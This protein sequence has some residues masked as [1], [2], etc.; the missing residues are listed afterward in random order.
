MR[1]FLFALGLYTAFVTTLIFDFAGGL[2]LR[3]GRSVWGRGLGVLVLVAWQ[4]GLRGE[5]L[6]LALV[7]ESSTSYVS[8][9]ETI[10]ALNDGVS[11]AHSDDKSSGAYGNWPR[12]GLQWVEYEWPRAIETDRV[13]VY[14]FDDQRGVRVPASVRLK[15]WDGGQF[16]EVGGVSGL[17]LERDKFNV[18]SFP[19]VSTRRLRLEFE[20]REEFS[21]GLL[22]WRVMDT[23]ASPN[24]AP[25][26]DAGVD[27]VVV[28]GGATHLEGV[29]RDDGKRGEV[30][31]NWVKAGG[32]GEVVFEDASALGTTAKFSV[33]GEYGVRLVANDGEFEAVD[34]VR[35]RVVGM[36]EGEPL[37]VVSTAGYSVSSSFW[38]GRLKP[39]VV[40]WIPHCI[41]KIEDV[42]TREGGIQNFVEAGRK[43][44]GGR[45]ARHVG[46]VFSNAWVYNTLE[47]MCW[48]LMLD[49]GGDEEV[50]E[51]QGMI[52]RTLED[53]IPKILSAQEPDGYLH[54]Q[55]TIEGRRRWSNKHDHED[56]MAG[57][58][59]EA[60]IAHWRLEGGKDRRMYDAA[61]RLADCWVRNLGEAGGRSWYPGHQ[62]MELALVRW[63]EL[64]EEVEGLGK[65][66]A[67]VGLSKWLLE[68]R[69]GGEEYDQS[70]V[71]VVRQ[72]EAVGHAV[73]AVYSYA[74]MVDIAMRT[75]DVDYHSAVMSIWDNLVNRKYYVTGGVGSGETS[76]GFG[77]D[78]SLPN[79][80]YCETCA[81]SGELFF[82]Y[83]MN[84]VYGG[85]RYADLMEETLYNAILGGMDL[86]GRNYTYTNPLDSGSARYGWHGCPCC[87]GNLPR[88]LLQLPTWMYVKGGGQLLVNM[89]VGSRVS[90]GEVSGVGVVV[91][92]ETDYPW[93]GV[94]KLRVEPERGVRFAL[95]LRVPDWETSE[96]YRLDPVVAG[97]A[98][99]RV[100]GEEEELVMHNGYAMVVREW[101]A[102]DVVEMELPMDIQRVRCDERVVA[103]RGRVAL[104]RGPLVYNFES[105]D[106]S[107]DGVL[108]AGSPLRS[109]WRGDL[110][111]GVEVIRGRFVDGEEFMAV[112]NYVRLN[113]GGRS[114]VWVREGR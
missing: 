28:V 93:G 107:V 52:R 109:E 87:V 84:R 26:V 102:G 7:A 74:G 13:E 88:T 64:V 98:K 58:F 80:A 76:E 94:V 36:P 46:P 60:A 30:T 77:E 81:G 54:T 39:L 113:R 44:A 40:N 105:V 78:Y 53:W 20:G 79:N 34:E 99:L 51:A 43:L 73:R 25:R 8:G 1:C 42:D 12:T 14:W 22:E 97:G 24:F 106:Q 4:A 75:G 70:H 35:V 32:A 62:E 5:G 41:R 57:Y 19:K 89:Y 108:S 66:D 100:N 103:N 104:R 96:L 17:G 67:Y 10:R 11:P 21:T 101:K 33:E 68:Q 37:E 110:L 31:V 91:E 71:P 90:V 69:R 65:G 2:F 72:Y 9:H 48:A 49:G 95:G 27:R 15:Y 86:E 82:Q 16:M 23:G 47:S 56:Y 6:N 114:V 55:Y 50:E 112:P 63:A 29:V 111:G 83:R 18:G 45:D 38:R 59:L 61:K 3:R 92:Q 85:A